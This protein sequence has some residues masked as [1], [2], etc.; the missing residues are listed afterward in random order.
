MDV[1]DRSWHSNLS[2]KNNPLLPQ[3]IRGALVGKSGCGKTNLLTNLLLRP[4][5]LDYDKLI[6]YGKSLHQPEYQVLQKGLERNIPK[7]ILD[8]VLS[9][10]KEVSGFNLDELLDNVAEQARKKGDINAEFHEDDESVCDPRQ[11]NPNDKNLIV[12][13]D[14]LLE[15]QNACERYYVRGRHNNVNCFYLSQNY[16][17]LPRHTIREN[18]N[19]LCIFP[20]DGKNLSHIYQDH[21]STDMP[22]DEFKRFCREAWKK[23]YNFITID[24]TSDKNR[25]RYRDGLDTF[26]IPE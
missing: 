10:A 23:P 24:L 22:F 16:F 19:F 6:V 8:N 1:K 7:D 26:Y 17:K 15:K 25:G 5:W 12:F 14:L 18:A 13:D 20:Q 9:Q 2:R 3:N 11:L 21:V 4:G